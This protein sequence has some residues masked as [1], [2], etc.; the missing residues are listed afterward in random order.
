MKHR[1]L[2]NWKAKVASLLVA[3][4]V[5][6]LLKGHVGNQQ[7]PRIV[8]DPGAPIA[9]AGLMS[10]GIFGPGREVVTPSAQ[11]AAER[12]QA[13]LLR[14]HWVESGAFSAGVVEFPGY[15]CA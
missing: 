15:P 8:S 6:Y 4:A 7:R 5:W 12:P 11:V 9:S 14:L 13:T 2:Y 3:V 10:D 1:I